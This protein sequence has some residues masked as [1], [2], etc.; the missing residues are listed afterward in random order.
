MKAINSFTLSLLSM[1]CLAGIL[2]VCTD[3]QKP[4]FGDAPVIGNNKQVIVS[5]T[6]VLDSS[7]SLKIV[8]AAGAEPLTYQWYRNDTAL[9]NSNTDSLGFEQLKLSDTGDYH[10]V[11][12]NILGSDK[13]MKYAIENIQTTV[14]ILNNKQIRTSGTPVKDSLFFMYITVSGSNGFYYRWY[15]NNV[16]VGDSEWV[17]SDKFSDT[18]CFDTLK[19]SDTGTYCCIVRNAGGT[20]QSNTFKLDD[21][22]ERPSIGNNKQLKPVGAPIKDSSFSLTVIVQSGSKPYKYKWY[23]GVNQVLNDTI[24]TLKFDSLTYND[25]GSYSCVVSNIYGKD[26][27]LAYSLSLSGIKPVI[28]NNKQVSVSGIPLKDAPFFMYITATGTKPLSYQWFK[29][30]I[31]VLTGSGTK[32][33]LKFTSLQYSDSGDFHCVAMNDF[34]ADTSKN[35]RLSL[36]NQPPQ[37]SVDTMHLT[38]TEALL[39]TVN[40]KD[41]CSDPDGDPLTFK[42]KSGAPVGDTITGVYFRFTPGYNDAGTYV[43]TIQAMDGKATTDCSIKLTVLNKNRAPYF[44]DTLPKTLYSVPEG[45]KLIINFKAVD[46]DGDLVSYKL[47]QNTL[48]DNGPV[49]FNDSQFVW[50]STNNDSGMYSVEIRAADKVDTTKAPISI[51]VGNV[52]RPPQIKIGSYKQGDTLKVKENDTLKFTVTATDPDAGDVPV[53][54]SPKNKPVGSVYDTSSGNF[55]YIPAFSVSTG[56][57]NTV[58][59]N[60]RFYAT[61]KKPQYNTDSF[62]IHIQVLDSNSAPKW[63]ITSA[64][65]AATEGKALNYNIKTAFSGDNEGDKVTFT[66]PFGIFNTDTSQWSWTPDFISFHGKD[67]LCSITATDNH[68]PPASSNLTLTVSIADSV[69]PAVLSKPSN[70]TYKSMK[71]SWTQSTEPQFGAYK[72][73]YDVSSTVTESSNL[74]ATITDI[75]KT[76][77]TLDGLNENTRYY[78][79]IFTY[80]AN[81]TKTGSNVVDSTTLV[82]NPPTLTVGSVT[83]T[84]DSCAIKLPVSTISGTAS[85]DAGISTVTAKINDAAVIVTGTTSWSFSIATATIKAWNK[86]EITATDTKGKTTTKIFQMFYKPALAISAA[87]TIS[88]STNRSMTVSWSQIAYCDR[89]LVYRATTNSG[90]YTVIKDTTSTSCRDTMLDINTQYWYEIRGYYSAA[91]NMRDS[92]DYSPYGNGTT[93]N[94]FECIYDFGGTWSGGKAITKTADGGYAIIGD[95]D[96]TGNYD[97]FYFKISKSGDVMWRRRIVEPDD[98]NGNYIQLTNDNGFIISGY[99][100]GTTTTYLMKMLSSGVLDWKKNYLSHEAKK[101]LQTSDNGYVMFCESYIARSSNTLLIKTNSSGDSLWG[102][103]F[104]SSETFGNHCRSGILIQND[105]SIALSLIVNGGTL[106]SKASNSGDSVWY[107]KFYWY[108]QDTVVDPYSIVQSNDGG[109]IIGGLHNGEA[110]LFKVKIYNWGSNVEWRRMYSNTTLSSMD[111]TIDGGC[112]F[113]GEYNSKVCLLKTDASGSQVWSPKYFGNNASGSCVLQTDDGGYIITGKIQI[114]GNYKVYVV[115]TDQNGNISN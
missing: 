44:L 18:L 3:P 59:P 96:S 98:Q 62:Y 71:I 52:N 102:R 32:D 2:F 110:T 79:R 55:S 54:L 70:L 81:N 21:I 111:K 15:K 107:Q 31:P 6:P 12:S 10:C 89:Y 23:K 37:W 17:S 115:K 103:A 104:N 50:Q 72:L 13:S 78:A 53:L 100:Q 75:Y 63:T 92:T 39:C 60:L 1:L 14:V 51:A 85:S 94:W 7:F 82:L 4:D 76:T 65:L 64:N 5:G 26:S 93:K 48:P 95:G 61:D 67:T 36:T 34:G 80:N 83:I 87:P 42:L 19:N 91:G 30:S 25:T 77:D 86:V 114:G 35:H 24:D 99:N 74:A 90:P 56:L 106:L 58:F 49:T 38:T 97:I 43:I 16:L 108:E 8:I 105:S 88:N 113:C 28:G 9:Q 68:N 33:T 84:N 41:S 66:K 109:Y 57:S 112:I 69:V 22:K 73:Y 46:P 101:V 20:D 47:T 29:D 45:T 40:V 11:V 27:S